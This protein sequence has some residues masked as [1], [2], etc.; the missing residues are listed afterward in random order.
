[1]AD[2]AQPG[3][4]EAATHEH[5]QIHRLLYMESDTATCSDLKFDRKKKIIKSEWMEIKLQMFI[6]QFSFHSNSSKNHYTSDSE[7]WESG[8]LHKQPKK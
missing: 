6:T 4:H 7:R 1:M 2:T 3:I 8:C 5:L